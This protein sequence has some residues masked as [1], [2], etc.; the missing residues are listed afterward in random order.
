MLEILGETEGKVVAT[1]AT[2]KLHQSDYD[3]VL[4]ILIDKEKTYEKIC[5]Y[6]EM[7]DFEGWD[8]KAAWEDVKF[9]FSHADQLEKIAMVGAKDWQEKLTKLMKPFTSA[10]VRFFEIEDREKAKSWIKG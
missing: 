8:V 6:F 2:G 7:E 1:K 9:S 5:W 3:K 10:E 4:P